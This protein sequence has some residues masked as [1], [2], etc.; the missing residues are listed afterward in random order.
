MKGKILIT[1]DSERRPILRFESEGLTH[2]G[3]AIILR[4]SLEA[5]DA[6]LE[7]DRKE[8]QKYDC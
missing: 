6:Y 3:I 2:E 5:H 1:A 7:K 4:A 8:D